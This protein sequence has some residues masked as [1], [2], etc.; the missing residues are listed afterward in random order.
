M[1]SIDA[2][3]GAC[4]SGR[5]VFMKEKTCAVC[6]CK[7]DSDSIKVKLRGEVADDLLSLCIDRMAIGK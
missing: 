4:R 3:G 5:R 6:G 7:L 1:G 2:S